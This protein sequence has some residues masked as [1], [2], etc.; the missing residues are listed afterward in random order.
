M[1]NDPDESEVRQLLL[2]HGENNTVEPEHRAPSPDVADNY[3]DDPPSP[4]LPFPPRFVHVNHP[5]M[6]PP[7]PPGMRVVTSAANVGLPRVTRGKKPG[8]YT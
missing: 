3:L 5:P 2:R 1:A 7:K 6:M 8:K 4:D